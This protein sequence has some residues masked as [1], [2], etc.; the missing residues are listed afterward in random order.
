MRE[1]AHSD[2]AGGQVGETRA[3]GPA[4]APADDHR[5]RAAHPH[6]TGVA[7]GQR[8]VLSALDLDQRIEHGRLGARVHLIDPETFSLAG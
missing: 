2:L 6:A 1:R 7:K 4:L 3:A 8:R 5:A